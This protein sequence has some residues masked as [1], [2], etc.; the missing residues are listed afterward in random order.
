MSGSLRGHRAARPAFE[1]TGR[2]DGMVVAASV[3]ALGISMPALA[4]VG[5]AVQGGGGFVGM[6]IEMLVRVFVG[7]VPRDVE[8]VRLVFERPLPAWGWFLSV[9]GALAVG[10]WSYRRLTGGSRTSSRVWRGSLAVVRAAV[11]VLVALLVAGPSLRFERTRTERDRLIVLV[12]RSMSMS[13]KDAPGGVARDDQAAAVLANAEPALARI[14]RTKDIEYVGFAGGVFTLQR[15]GSRTSRSSSEDATDGEGAVAATGS[16]PVERPALGTSSGERTDLDIALR[17]A[18]ARA[19]GRPVSGVLLLSDGRSASPVSA[20]ALEAF[21][22]DS[23]PVHAVA[24]GSA[25]RLG[26]AAIVGVA[27]PGR[28]FV[29][30]RVPVEV[31]VDRG[32]VSGEVAVRLVDASTGAEIAR[33]AVPE[34]AEGEAAGETTVVLDGASEDAGSRAWRVEIV[35]E[36]PDLVRENDRSEVAV[37][38]IDRPL[39]VLYVEGASRWEYRY[40]KNL[41]MREKDIESSI[42]LLSADRDFAQEGNMPISRLPR[43]REEFSKYDLFVIGDVPSGFFSPDQ[44]AILRSEVADR[45]AGLL[46]IGGDRSTPSSWE[47]TPLADLMPFKPPFA[48]DA[49][50]GSSALA[51]TTAAARLGVMRLSD[52]DDGWPDAFVDPAIRWSKLRYVQS[53]PR[54]RVKPTA[55]VLAMAEGSGPIGEEPTPAVMRMRFGAGDIVYVATDEIWRWRYGQG[56]RLPERFWVPIV[57]LLA[58]ESIAQGEARA[59]LAVAPGRIAPGESTVVSLRIVDE[60]SAAKAPG[61]VPV[62][63]RDA[64]GNPV[65]RIELTREEGDASAF[66]VPERTGRFTAIAEDPAFGRVE[67]PFE[68]VRDDDELRRGDADHAALAEVARRTGGRMLDV[69]SVRGLAEILPLRARETDESTERT[70]WDTWP[71]LFLLLGLLAI[72]WSGRRLLRLV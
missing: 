24:L 47:S 1:R 5:D 65:A 43:T 45:G 37:E 50:T 64:D 11:L 57:R 46:W 59:R 2:S 56:E 49:R 16:T 7:E 58:R 55:E 4:S 34:S 33:K 54:A 32:G 8:A 48:L 30:D 52:E 72:E 31:R 36:R 61:V 62:E 60:E 28:A 22:R 67:A 27:V 53:V 71:A 23:I 38:F 14:A 17:Q 39:R 68:V 3:A 40:L 12:D 26:D 15:D 9:M 25:T 18:L 70:I 6:P 63:V 41:L 10:W 44:L 13:I 29:R 20:D 42:M 66:F 21:E 35:S 51:P 19:A 69:D